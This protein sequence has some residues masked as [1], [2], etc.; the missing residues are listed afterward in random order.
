[1][2]PSDWSSLAPAH[3]LAHSPSDNASAISSS[4]SVAGSS[5]YSA[6]L[7]RSELAAHNDTDRRAVDG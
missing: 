4:F 1:M 7:D 5:A 2:L 6:A 3:K